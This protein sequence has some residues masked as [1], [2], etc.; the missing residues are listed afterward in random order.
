MPR[1]S[2]RFTI[3]QTMVDIRRIGIDVVTKNFHLTA[4]GERGEVVETKRLG[5]PGDRLPGRLA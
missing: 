4:A 5:Q 1:K 3:W 2:G